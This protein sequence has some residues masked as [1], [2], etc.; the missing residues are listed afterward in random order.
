MSSRKN[1]VCPQ[2]QRHFAS[3][4]GLAQHRADAHV[5]RKQP[6]PRVRNTQRR[7]GGQSTSVR[8]SSI[9]SSGVD[10]VQSVS[11]SKSM[12]AGTVLLN[13]PLGPSHLAPSRWR[14]ESALWSRWR[15][16]N[17]RLSVVGSGASTTFGSVC[18]AWCPDFNWVP[19]GNSSDYM[20]VAA[21]RPSVTMRLHESRTLSVP[22]EMTQKWYHCDGSP[23]TSTHG[24]VLV[25]VAAPVGGFDGSVGLTITLEWSVAFE[26]IEMPGTQSA[27]DDVIRPDAGWSNLFTTSD[28]SFESSVLTLKM[29]SGGAM[30][31]FSAARSDHVY[32]PTAD[33]VVKYYDTTGQLLTAKY[34]ARVHGYAIPG[35]L[36]FSTREDAVSYVVS[37]DTTKA[38]KFS[39]AG[40]VSTPALPKFHGTSAHAVQSV[41][42]PQAPAPSAECVRSF[43]SPLSLKRN[44]VEEVVDAKWASED[45]DL[46]EA[47]FRGFREKKSGE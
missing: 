6:G 24:S 40:P 15:P 22:A 25:V 19:V 4:A 3:K 29:H 26:G 12:A 38:L 20:R 2:C 45:Y 16:R 13:L 41:F 28:G 17:L 44:E 9:S 36:L 43:Y 34:F 35:L 39:K 8:M 23:E 37:G 33:T 31:P 11:C 1:I 30:A 14:N 10:L 27:I 7:S 32:E 18:V 21:L 47:F 46:F 5:A 42:N